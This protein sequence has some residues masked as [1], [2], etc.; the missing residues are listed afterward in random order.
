MLKLALVCLWT[1]LLHGAQ[2]L[3][4]SEKAMAV[5]HP[6]DQPF[7]MDEAVCAVQQEKKIA[8]GRVAKVSSKGAIVRLSVFRGTAH[9]GDSVIR[10]SSRKTA[11]TSSTTEAVP[12]PSGRN[13]FGGG[14]LGGTA[15]QYTVL[16]YERA[17]SNKLSFRVEPTYFVASLAVD[18]GTSVDSYS[19]KTVGTKLGLNFY[20]LAP[21]QG[22]WINAG[23]GYYSFS[24]TTLTAGASTIPNFGTV[25]ASAMLGFR[26][27]LGKPVSLGLCVGGQYLPFSSSFGV[28]ALLPVGNMDLSF[29][30]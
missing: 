28:A 22:F 6:G 27:K 12:K 13:S 29:V 20:S 23:V 30:F 10:L 17:F 8:C 18:N 2:V 25:V 15:Y 21:F 14:F 5:S 1:G 24:I 7:K 19:S 11:S 26:A 4:I 3:Q 9:K 16:F